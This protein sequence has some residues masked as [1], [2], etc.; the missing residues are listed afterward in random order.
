MSHR[1]A[2]CQTPIHKKANDLLGGV[3]AEQLPLV[4]FVE[5]NTRRLNEAHKVLGGE[6]TERTPDK[7]R[8]EREEV[9]RLGV[10]VGEVTATAP[11]DTNLFPDCFCV[12]EHNGLH[13][14]PTRNR[15]AKESCGSRANH[16]QVR[17]IRQ[18]R[19]CSFRTAE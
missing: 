5:T 10:S 19:G 2:R 14:E 8:I 16:H 15:G 17:R 4:F 3:I 11:A 7:V 12:I 6:A 13:A 9:L 1:N 18:S